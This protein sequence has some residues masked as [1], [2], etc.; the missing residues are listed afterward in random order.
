MKLLFFMPMD[1]HCSSMLSL[2]WK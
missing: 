1:M 2:L